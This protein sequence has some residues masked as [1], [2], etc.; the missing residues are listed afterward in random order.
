MLNIKQLYTTLD[1]LF[2]CISGLSFLE[3]I[4]LIY[5]GNLML[6][7]IDSGIKIGSALI[8]LIY[9]ALRIYFYYHKSKEEISFLKQQTIDLELKNKKHE[10]Q[11]YLFAKDF[12]D[13]KEEEFEFS[14]KR[15]QKNNLNK[16]H[17]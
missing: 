12:A 5:S 4:P 3:L 1:L 2:G 7:N 6:S 17:E 9:F 14:R 15:L 16:Q 8:G 11:N 13:M 10:V